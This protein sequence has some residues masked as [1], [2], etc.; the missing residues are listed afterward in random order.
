[1]SITLQCAPQAQAEAQKRAA[2]AAADKKKNFF[3][4]SLAEAMRREKTQAGKGT[5]SPV[6]GGLLRGSISASNSK[7]RQASEGCSLP[8]RAGIIPLSVAAR[9]DS[10]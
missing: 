9:A 1:M 2:K 4:S 10:R 3:R 8:R 6:G 7:A 5:H